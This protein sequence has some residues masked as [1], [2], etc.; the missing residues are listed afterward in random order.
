MPRRS[1]ATWRTSDRKPDRS[2][3]RPAQPRA[4][5]ERLEQEVARRHRDGGD[6][7]LAVLDIDHFK[8]INDDFGHLAGDKVLKIIAGELRKRLRQA[9]FIARFGG[10][11]FVVLLPATSLEAPATARTAARGDRRLSVPFQGRRPRASPVPPA[12]PR[13]KATRPA[14]RF[15]SVPTRRCIEPSAP[16]GTAW[17]WPE[18]RP[19]H[20]PTTRDGLA[21]RCCRG[22]LEWSRPVE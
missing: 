6:L 20:I 3:D 12:S 21:C 11:E 4:L 22:S 17:K 2:A 1:T 16:A 7:L 10:E 14:K 18:G 9:D 13:S 8:R 15:S 5:S 19:A